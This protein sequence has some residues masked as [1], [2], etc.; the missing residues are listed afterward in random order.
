MGRFLDLFRNKYFLLVF[1][2]I[3]LIIAIGVSAYNSDRF[4]VVRDMVDVPL[5]PVQKFFTDVF[6]GTAGVIQSFKDIKYL[7]QENEELKARINELER[8]NR[9][10]LIY[11]DKIDELKTALNLKDQFDNY[12][13]V[14]ANVIAK[15]PGNW[16]HIFKIDVGT[17]DS[18][19]ADYPVVSGENGLVGRITG[20]DRR[21]SMVLSILDEDSSVSGWISKSNGGHVIVKGDVRLKEEGLCRMNF[22]SSSVNVEVGDVIETSGLG[23]IYPK[24]ILIGKVVK[25]MESADSM[26]IYGVIEPESDFK[27][28]EEVYVLSLKHGE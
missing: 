23:G 10:Y 2:T 28:L 7:K 17:S 21:S 15:E 5:V 3:I 1:V 4:S 14:G 25:V 16:F 9:Q 11:K 19:M 20:T 24:G 22:D 27:R 8:E 12:D 13:I 26:E 18:V 6:N